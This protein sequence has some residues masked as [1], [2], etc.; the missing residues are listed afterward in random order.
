[1]AGLFAPFSVVSVDNRE[2][3]LI[4]L[5]ALGKWSLIDF[6]VMVLFSNAFYIQMWVGDQVLVDV[7]CV[8]RWGFYSFVFATMMSLVCSH[9]LLGCHRYIVEPKELPF[10]DHYDPKESLSSI[11]YEMN[12]SRMEEMILLPRKLSDLTSSEAES[13]RNN[14]NN[15]KTNHPFLVPSANSSPLKGTADK[16]DNRLTGERLF[17]D[18]KVVDFPPSSLIK[19]QVN[20]EEPQEQEQEA[21]LLD[22]D[23]DQSTLYVRFTWFGKILITFIVCVTVF[24]I[25]AGSFIQTMGF[26]FKGLVGFFLGI[27]GSERIDYSFVEI[28]LDVPSHSGMPNDP[29]VRWMQVSFFLFG[30]VMPLALMTFILVLWLIPLTLTYQRIIYVVAQ[31][32]N[33]WSALDVFCLAIAASLLEIQ[34]FAAF[35]FRDYCGRINDILKEYFDDAMDGDDKCIDVVAYLKY[36]SWLVFVAATLILLVGTIVLRICNFAIKQRLANAKTELVNADLL[37]QHIEEAKKK[38][39]EEI[40]R[41]ILLG[42]HHQREQRHSSNGAIIGEKSLIDP[43]LEAAANNNTHSLSTPAPPYH[44]PISGQHPQED[45][46]KMHEYYKV[47]PDSAYTRQHPPLQPGD[48]PAALLTQRNQSQDDGASFQT[49]IIGSESSSQKHHLPGQPHHHHHYGR[50]KGGDSRVAGSKG[51]GNGAG[52]QADGRTNSSASQS[53]ADSSSSPSAPFPLNYFFFCFQA[54][55]AP[56]WCC[57]SWRKFQLGVLKCC[58]AIY[59]LK[60]SPI[61]ENLYPQDERELS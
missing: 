2:T 17:S 59:I 57:L 42:D 44:Y 11:V 23:D 24:F 26:E 7:I 40:E 34:Q 56:F 38:E 39:A 9:I 36:Q 43:L 48:P 29:G 1:M 12:V 47:T 30:L 55:S 25:I 37:R 18:K 53:M 58:E 14:N 41:Q 61:K 10:T 45:Y 20:E 49:I 31:C 4:V 19:D 52:D 15:T 60:L 46:L 8:P 16:A 27:Q 21:F 50:K 6:F 3:L 13:S 5:D 51:S 32:L 28:G 33:A 22:Q 35:V 54:I